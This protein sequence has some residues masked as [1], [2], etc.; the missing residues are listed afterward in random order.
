M[1][2]ALLIPLAA[3]LA[4]CAPTLGVSD[5]PATLTARPGQ[6]TFTPHGTT[7][8]TGVY[9]RGADLKVTDTRCQPLRLG[10]ACNLG[11]VTAPVTLTVTGTPDFG[12]ATFYRDAQ[13]APVTRTL[14]R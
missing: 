1:K 8:L 6:V 5:D 14:E 7:T 13:R 3:L 10:W 2:R 12:A 4:A 11:T 9:L